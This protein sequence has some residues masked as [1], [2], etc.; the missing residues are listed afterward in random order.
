MTARTRRSIAQNG[1]VGLGSLSFS[2]GLFLMVATTCIAAG[3]SLTWLVVGNAAANL[4]AALV[5]FAE[6]CAGFLKVIG[7]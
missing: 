2:G 3:N 4:G 5:I 7:R 6:P 1:L